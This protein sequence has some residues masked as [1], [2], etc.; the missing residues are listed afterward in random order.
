MTHTDPAEVRGHETTPVSAHE[1]WTG[2]RA[3]GRAAKA[4]LPAST[5]TAQS[6]LLEEILQELRLARATST[7]AA[8][9]GKDL[10]NGILDCGVDAFDSN[11]QITRQ[12]GVAIGSLVVYNPAVT[13]VTLQGAPAGSGAPFKGRGVQI[14]PALGY[15]TMP[16]GSHTWTAYG[17]AGNQLAFQVFTGLQAYGVAG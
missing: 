14:V 4:M 6:A 10:V 17:L 11:G 15:W 2:I 16:I 1:D 9:R 3:A 13:P 5:T 7:A 8:A 12:Y